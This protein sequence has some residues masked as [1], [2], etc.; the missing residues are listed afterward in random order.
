MPTTMQ[1][2]NRIPVEYGKVRVLPRP[3][4]LRRFAN[5]YQ[6]GQ[7]TTFLGPTQRGKTTLAFQM[8]NGV[9]SPERKTTVLAGKPPQRDHTMNLVGDALN[10][11]TVEEWPPTWNPKDRN[12]NGFVIRPYQSLRDIDADMLNLKTQFRAAMLDSYSATK[13]NILMVDEASLIYNDLGLKKEYESILMRGAP[14][15]AE[16]S[17]IQRGRGMSYHAYAAPEHV[18]IFYDPDITN[19]KRYSEMIGGVDPKY[20]ADIVNSL[21]TY[22]VKTGGTIS[23]ALYIRRSGPEIYVVDVK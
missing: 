7:H 8:L 23:E 1:R 21:R 9:V 19:V 4:F 22:R 10:L 18:L 11:R 5:D 12:R 14:T 13:P 2:D 6:N 17:L 16:W 15:T 3:V 20:I